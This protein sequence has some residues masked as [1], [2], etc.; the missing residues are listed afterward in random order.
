MSFKFLISYHYFRTYELDEALPRWFPDGVPEI[1]ADS[2]AYSAMTQGAPIDRAKYGAW[3]QR[4][5]HHFSVYAN[6]DV[7]GDGAYAASA[8]AGNQRFLE[9]LGLAPLPV[10]HAGEPWSALEALLDGG[11]GYIGLGGLVGRQAKAIMPWLVKCFKLAGDRAVFHGFGLTLWEC[12]A[13][14]PFYSVDST[15]WGSSYRYGRLKLFDPRLGRFVEAQMNREAYGE[16]AAQLIR[17]YGFDPADFADKSRYDRART[18]WLSARS[19][20]A[21]ERWLRARHGT[22]HIPT[23]RDL[24]EGLRL[25]CAD[26]SILNLS[27]GAA[28]LKLYLADTARSGDLERLGTLPGT[29]EQR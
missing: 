27:D 23:D 15:S 5:K 10:F 21:A 12:I 25:Y 11:A 24:P 4:Y 17:S 8:T 16:G 22:I 20:E 9:E 2:G 1:F 28:G 14:F 19:W 3:L 6:L 18:C 7:I 13:A 29:E 26:G